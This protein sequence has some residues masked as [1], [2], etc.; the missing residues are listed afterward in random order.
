MY[1]HTNENVGNVEYSFITITSSSTMTWREP[2]RVPST[3]QIEL[4]NHLTMMKLI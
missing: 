4:F 2:V 3:D 1:A